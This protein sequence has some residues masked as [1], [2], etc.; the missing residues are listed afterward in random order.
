MTDSVTVSKIIKFKHA[1]GVASDPTV[2]KVLKLHVIHVFIMR[3]IVLKVS[4]AYFICETQMNFGKENTC[5][6]RTISSVLHC[7][8]FIKHLLRVWNANWF[9]CV[10]LFGVFW[11]IYSK[12][13][14]SYVEHIF[15]GNKC[16]TLWKSQAFNLTCL[17]QNIVW[18]A[19]Q[20]FFIFSHIFHAIFIL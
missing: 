20:L 3:E 6:I 11:Q 9:V 8:V 10:T 15:G 2:L 16:L 17:S 4:C 19:F 1:F 7:T 12:C 5:I 18:H 14:L 13:C